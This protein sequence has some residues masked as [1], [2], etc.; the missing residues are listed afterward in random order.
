MTKPQETPPHR[1]KNFT[2]ENDMIEERRIRR[3][4]RDVQSLVKKCIIITILEMK[5]CIKK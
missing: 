1:Q 2:V 3:R 4:N 5:L